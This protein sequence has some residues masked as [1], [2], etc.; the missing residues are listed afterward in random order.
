MLREIQEE[1]EPAGPLALLDRAAG[2]ED[3]PGARIM[4]FP[5]VNDVIGGEGRPAPGSPEER[6]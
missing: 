1:A 5:S 6:E 3:R 4:R 2:L